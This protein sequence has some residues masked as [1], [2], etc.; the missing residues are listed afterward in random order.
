MYKTFPKDFLW[1]TAIAAHQVEG[2]NINSD[3]WAEEYSKGSP[4]GDKSGDA[5][6]H[7]R[8]YTEGIKLMAELGLKTYRFSIE[9]TFGYNMYFG[10][11]GVDRSTQE[12][13]VKESAHFLGEI[14]Q[15][16]GLKYSRP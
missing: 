15:N 1:G 3:V 12:R 10:V 4:Y 13:L 7:Y 11:I 8:L 5:V 14:A 16:N 9:W 6:D 2:N